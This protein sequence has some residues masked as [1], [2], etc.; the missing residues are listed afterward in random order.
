MT[1]L[2]AIILSVAISYIL[3]GRRESHSLKEVEDIISKFFQALDEKWGEDHTKLNKLE[4]EV[5]LLR[6]NTAGLKK[7]KR[8]KV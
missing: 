5:N 2:I 4:Q 8:E 3:F 7:T 6:I 1:I